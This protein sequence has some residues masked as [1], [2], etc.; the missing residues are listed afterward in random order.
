[1]LPGVFQAQKK[2]GTVYYRSSFT[3]QNKHISLG[4][5]P[6]EWEAHTVYAEANNIMNST[7]IIDDYQT[8]FSIKFEKYVSLINF[9]DNGIYIKTPC[10]LKKTYFYYYFAPG[11]YL[12][13][14]QNDLF[15][16]SSHKIMRRNG[17]LFVADYGMQ[18]NILS[19][20][21][22]KN[23]A[24]AGKDYQFK[25][26]DS[27]DFRYENIEVINPY[28]GVSRVLKKDTIC[29]K[30]KIHLRSEYV[31]G[32]FS[33]AVTAAIAYNKAVDILKKNGF[34]KDFSTNYIEN[35]SPKMYAEVY[36]DIVLPE[37]IT[38][39]KPVN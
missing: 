1:M 31:I 29:Y 27:S 36:S 39:L 18:V 14:D 13:F 12:I 32:Y 16:Y 20:Y 35:F 24:V 11:D 19:R 10:Y 30:A 6:T 8:T 7:C 15:Y 33:D 17:H 26:E 38:N 21:G 9:R 37:N 2:D 3:H 4:S 23:H 34:F 22:I 5:Y 28:Y 25:N